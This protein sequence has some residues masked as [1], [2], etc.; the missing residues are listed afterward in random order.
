MPNP[1]LKVAT[2]ALVRSDLV[3]YRGDVTARLIYTHDEKMMYGGIGYSPTNSIT[4]Y[5]GMFIQ[6]IVLG[7]CYESYIG[8]V[9]MKS[10]AHELR[11]GYRTELQLGKKGK[12]FHQSVRYL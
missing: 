3:A 9:G 5:V 1:T 4:A 10:G 7:Y 12:N 6:G 11:V 8:G 2:S